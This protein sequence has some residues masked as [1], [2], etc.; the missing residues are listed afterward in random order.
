MNNLRNIKYIDVNLDHSVFVVKIKQDSHKLMGQA[1]YN[2]QT[3][4]SL[5]FLAFITNKC[6]RWVLQA[7]YRF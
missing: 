3:T 4:H 6:V 5:L 1:K 2:W 7:L